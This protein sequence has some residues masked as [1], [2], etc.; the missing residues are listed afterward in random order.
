MMNFLPFKHS[1]VAFALCTAVTSVAFTACAHAQE[2]PKDK[3][4]QTLSAIRVSAETNGMA[5]DSYRVTDVGRTIW[6]M[7]FDDRF[8]YAYN[9]ETYEFA[10]QKVGSDKTYAI[11]LSKRMDQVPPAVVEKVGQ[12]ITLL[13]YP[14]TQWRVYSL[15]ELCGDVFTSPQAAENLGLN[16]ADQMRIQQGTWEALSREPLLESKCANFAI[17]PALGKVMGYALAF[18]GKAGEGRITAIDASTV[19]PNGRITPIDMMRAKEFDDEARKEIRLTI[20]SPAR[21]E[22][23]KKLMKGRTTKEAIRLLNNM[24]QE[25]RRKAQEQAQ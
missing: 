9:S 16:Y 14:T 10:V 22:E 23:F 2:T 4:E 8:N 20:Y 7:S 13:G 24:R 15:G 6:S 1:L 21:Q 5:S 3:T 12:G 19:L 25:E 18:S 11:N 17:K